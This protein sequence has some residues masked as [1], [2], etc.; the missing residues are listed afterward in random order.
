MSIGTSPAVKL[1]IQSGMVPDNVLQQ[2]ANWKLLPE[3]SKQS[4]GSPQVSLEQEWDSIE[5][6]VAQLRDA[7]SKEFREIRETDLSRSGGFHKALLHYEESGFDA[8]EEIF[9][10]R[11]GRVILPASEPA[12]RT[13]KGVTLMD[14]PPEIRQEVVKTEVRY[15]GEEE[16]DL[17][18]YLSKEEHRE[19]A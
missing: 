19:S 1:I 3:G 10:D 13:L 6:F 18:L 14:G 17:V 2:L 15:K 9:V 12:Y 7:L 11:L 5:E 4:S 16:T 8:V